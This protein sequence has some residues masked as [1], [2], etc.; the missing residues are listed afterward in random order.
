MET[1]RPENKRKQTSLEGEISSNQN[2][3]QLKANLNE[4]IRDK[5]L[6]DPNLVYRFRR[7]R[8]INMI[9]NLPCREKSPAEDVNK[10]FV[11]V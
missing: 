9:N 11:I 2:Q 8:M 10:T 1:I 3:L 4:F 5:K 7:L 6:Q